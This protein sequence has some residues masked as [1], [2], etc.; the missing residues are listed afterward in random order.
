VSVIWVYHSFRW[1]QLNWYS[2]LLSLA[3]SLRDG[4]PT[5]S[6]TINT[7]GLAVRLMPSLVRWPEGLDTFQYQRPKTFACILEYHSLICSFV[8]EW[9][10][11]FGRSSA[12]FGNKMLHT[13][14]WTRQFTVT[15]DYGRFN[16]VVTLRTGTQLYN[17]RRDVSN[18]HLY[19]FLLVSPPQ[20]RLS[21]KS[22]WH[23]PLSTCRQGFNRRYF[24]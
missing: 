8:E 5:S 21:T 13:S 24:V 11:C 7:K 19:L 18:R 15:Q 2:Y 14:L 20:P 12:P 3:S 17:T 23:H 6:F 10:M 16:P 4:R 1:H 9:K 22:V